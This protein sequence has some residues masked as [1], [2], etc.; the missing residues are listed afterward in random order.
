MEAAGGLDMRLGFSIDALDNRLLNGVSH[1][2]SKHHPLHHDHHDAHDR[3]ENDGGD[4]GSEW[5]IQMRRGIGKL[6]HIFRILRS[7]L[8]PNHS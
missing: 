8:S 6:D 2:P 3:C 1:F 4:C 7:M 5:R